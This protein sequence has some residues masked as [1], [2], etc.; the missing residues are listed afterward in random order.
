MPSILSSLFNVGT[1]Y[2][3]A[4]PQGVAITQQKLAEEVSPFY[5]DLLQKSQA[6]HKER[7]DEG[8]IPYTGPTIADWTPEQQQAFTG[9]SGLVGTQAPIFDEATALTRGTTA[10]F[11]P[12]K[13]QELMTTLLNKL[14]DIFFVLWS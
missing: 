6:L 4:P 3:S 10:Q 14:L 1:P 2:P 5:K 7:S 11:T 9:I 13:A 8:Y 12:E